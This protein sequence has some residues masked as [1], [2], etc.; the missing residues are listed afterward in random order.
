MIVTSIPTNR[1]SLPSKRPFG[2]IYN[3][4]KQYLKVSGIYDKYNL[5]Q[6]DPG[7]YFEKYS[8][9]P[10]KRIAGK[11]GQ[12]LQKRFRTPKRRYVT[13]RYQQYQKQS[14]D[15]CWNNWNK[16]GFTS[17]KGYKHAF[18]HGQLRRF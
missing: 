7:Y 17:C 3:I 10:R 2:T 1:P 9:K 8:Y 18:E 14:Y 4:G 6:Y 15:S 13:K 12:E 16:S 5:R 11:L